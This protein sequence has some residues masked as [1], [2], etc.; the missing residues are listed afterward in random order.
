ME[1]TDENTII[2]LRDIQN[3]VKSAKKEIE[4]KA[5]ELEALKKKIVINIK[6]Y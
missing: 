5:N 4:I 6:A 3:G 1:I 2:L